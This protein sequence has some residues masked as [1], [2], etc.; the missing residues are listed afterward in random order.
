MPIGRSYRGRRARAGSDEG[1]AEAWA[2]AAALPSRVTHPLDLDIGE[3]ALGH[4]LIV[5]GITLAGTS[6]IL[7]WAFVPEVAE[8]D[9]GEVWPNMC[10]DADVSPR[11]WNGGVSDW[12][13]FDRP[14]PQARLVWFDFFR[15]DFD[16]MAHF[17]RGGKP[18]SD[19][20]SN[21]I[22]R[23]VFNLKTAKGHL[24]R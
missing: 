24:E 8:E 15:P 14:V 13:G 23:L 10:Y 6:L 18:D 11:G 16:P 20:L 4:H 7:E 19:Y 22:A 17:D 1:W 2:A 12:D 9:H 21:R 5:Q 3:V